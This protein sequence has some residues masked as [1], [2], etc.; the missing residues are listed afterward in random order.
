MDPLVSVLM[1]CYNSVET[2]PLALA[3]LQT[4]T[5]RN[6]ECV[7]I[8]DGSTDCPA[9]VVQW[10]ND[11]RIRYFRHS[12]NLGR[13]AARQSSLTNARGSF[14][15]MLDADDWIYADKLAKQ[16]E[17]LSLD[18]S[19]AIISSALGIVDIEGH[20]RGVRG[21][22]SADE[23]TTGRNSGSLPLF[24]FAPSMFR[25]EAAD[26]IRFNERFTIGEDQDFLNRIT[27]GRNYAILTDVYYIYT[28]HRSATL[29]KTLAANARAS[30]DFLG[31]KDQFPVSSRWR[32]FKTRA[33]RPVY[34][35]AHAM[36]LWDFLVSMRSRTPTTSQIAKFRE[37][38]LQANVKLQL[39]SSAASIPGT[40]GP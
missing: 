28:E 27:L 36:G 13:G 10:F 26:G 20:L 17:I 25:A 22:R 30:A 37:E 7:L 35:A 19:L 23:M 2:L 11:P 6:W 38:T 9:R 18:P 32:A 40:L 21:P 24:P 31:N 8:D 1:P 34:M 39:C 33:R 14:L 15:T 16:A 12:R 5:W 4:Q 29:S 3:S